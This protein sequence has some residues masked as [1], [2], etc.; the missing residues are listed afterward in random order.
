M[1]IVAILP[2]RSCQNCKK[3]FVPA[4][5]WQKFCTRVCQYENENKKSLLRSPYPGIKVGTVGAIQ[6]LKVAVDLMSKG[7][8][9]FRAMSPHSSCDLAVLRSGKLYK[10]E[11]R[12]AYLKSDGTISKRFK[13]E[14]AKSSDIYY[15]WVAPTGIDYWPE[16]L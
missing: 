6:E 7:Y 16:K 10:L 2:K 4:R 11:V 5:R 9:V 15:A 13:S 3:E 8:E 14:A 1:R 12:T